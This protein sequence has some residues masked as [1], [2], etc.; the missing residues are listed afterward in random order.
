MMHFKLLRANPLGIFYI[1]RCVLIPAFIVSE[2]GGRMS[3]MSVRDVL[4]EHGAVSVVLAPLLRALPA[5]VPHHRDLRS[6]GPRQLSSLPR[7]HAS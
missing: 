7:K 6:A 4:W 3:T 2:R 1:P 5:A